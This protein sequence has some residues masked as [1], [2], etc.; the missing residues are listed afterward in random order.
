MKQTIETIPTFFCPV[1][2]CKEY[3]IVCREVPD[4]RFRVDGVWSSA[5]CLN[6]N[7]IYL[8]A[9]LD[10]SKSPC[11][12]PVYSQHS[13]PD[14]TPLQGKGLSGKMK[15]YIRKS[16]LKKHGYNIEKGN[17]FLGKLLQFFPQIVLKAQW[18]Q[19]IF[20]SAMPHG[21]LLD[22]GCGNGRFLNIMGKLGWLIYG[23]EPDPE[24]ALIAQTTSGALIYPSLDEIK[25]LPFQFDII[26]MN[27]VLEHIQNPR[28][29]L[30]ACWLLLKPAGK[31]AIS[32]PNWGSLCRKVFN[33]YWYGLDAPRHKILYECGTLKTLLQESG[34][35]EH[36]IS[37]TS[38]REGMVS[39]RKSYFFRFGRSPST[40][41]KT[42]WFFVSMLAELCTSSLGEEIIAWARK[43]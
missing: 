36:I 37:T 9:P 15:E 24:S 33:K 5:R 38:I 42:S 6:C 22:I 13:T 19:I 2:R 32:T 14:V 28:E 29:V 8:V 16:I 25:A 1:C 3:V 21:R 41:I 30:N 40:I 43:K 35:S 26:T 12:P 10:D 17:C 34:F 31:I 4:F 39:F 20:P 11:P 18:G 27:H 7:V 23:V